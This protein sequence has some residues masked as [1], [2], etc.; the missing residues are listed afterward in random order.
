M[1]LGSNAE[2][3]RCLEA[4]SQLQLP[5]QEERGGR[6]GRRPGEQGLCVTGSVS[7]PTRRV[8]LGF[9]KIASDFLLSDFSS[10]W[11]VGV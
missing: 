10:Y 9:E 1:G 8:S 6:N 4:L 7:C 11:S 2:S 5:W 3:D